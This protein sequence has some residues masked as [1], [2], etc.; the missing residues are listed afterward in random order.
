MAVLANPDTS[1][2][3]KRGIFMLEELLCQELPDP[4]P[5]IPDLPALRPGL[6]TRAR[7]EQHRA[8]P[9]CA[10]CHNLIDPLGMAFENYDLHRPLAHDR[11]RACPS[12]RRARSRQEHR[13]ATGSFASGMELLGK[14]PG[15]QAV[16]DCMARRW[17]EYAYSRALDGSSR[18]IAARWRR[19]R[20]AS[21]RTAIWS[22]CWRRSPAASRSDRPH[23]AGTGEAT[24]HEQSVTADLDRRALLARMG[25]AA[26]ALP[27]LQATARPGAGPGRG[28]RPR[29]S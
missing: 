14:L 16:R 11:T 15:S 26:L 13:P 29:T 1:D 19:P 12:I 3:I 21:G 4:L 10:G 7:L 17:A 22:S 24:V 8:D 20:P 27:F 28:P 25:G 6:S 18:P 5:D 23:P 2:P 9:V